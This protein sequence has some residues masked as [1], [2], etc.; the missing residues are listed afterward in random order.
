MLTP[1]RERLPSAVA[2][3]TY[4]ERIHLHEP[5]RFGHSMGSIGHPIGKS[6]STVSRELRRNRYSDRSDAPHRAWDVSAALSAS[7]V[8]CL[9][10][11]ETRRGVRAALK[12]SRQ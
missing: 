8:D 10:R 9:Q 12:P 7:V 1:T 11:R 6:K 4:A 5:R 2:H 3:L